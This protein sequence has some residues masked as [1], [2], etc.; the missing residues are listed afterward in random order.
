MFQMEYANFSFSCYSLSKFYLV[1]IS[2]QKIERLPQRKQTKNDAGSICIGAV[3]N[4][5]QYGKTQKEKL[6]AAKN[7]S[8]MLQ[9]IRPLPLFTK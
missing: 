3:G 7:L 1:T 6:D 5:Y 9:K 4:V 8:N 2:P